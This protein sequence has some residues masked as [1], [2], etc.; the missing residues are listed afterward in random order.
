MSIW[1]LKDAICITSSLFTGSP[2][3]ILPSSKDELVTVEWYKNKTMKKCEY[4]IGFHN[5]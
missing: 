1:I 3:I 5:R 4:F 2:F